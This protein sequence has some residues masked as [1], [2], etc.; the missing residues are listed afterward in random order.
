MLSRI[1]VNFYNW[2]YGRLNFKGAGF[3][4]SWVACFV[5][6]LQKFPLTVQ[7]IGEIK[8][9]FRDVSAFEWLNFLI[10]K[11]SQERGLITAMTQYSQPNDV[12]WDIGA[13][14]GIISAHFA[15]PEYKLKA[16][17]AFEPNPEIFETLSYLFIN[18]PIFHGHNFALASERA[19]KQLLVPIGCSCKGS[20]VQQQTRHKFKTFSVECY[21]GDELVDN[22]RVAPP[23]LVKIDVEGLE[24]DVL[25]GMNSIL[26][27][28]KPVVFLEHL[29]LDINKLSVFTDYSIATISSADGSL[30]AGFLPDCGHN[31]ALIPKNTAMQGFR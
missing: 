28:Y 13:N 1:L 10:G 18:N 4:L 17:Y 9:D 15:N 14:I 16:I 12:L 19:Q 29:F 3:F 8:V 6:A 20:L 31:I 23:S 11:K 26:K 30:H 5:P 24:L 21:T 22:G 27:K 2:W 7:G 25:T